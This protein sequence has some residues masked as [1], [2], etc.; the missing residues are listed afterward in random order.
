MLNEKRTNIAKIE[1]RNNVHII[2]VPNPHM[3]TPHFEVER[4]RD[5]STVVTQNENSY[6]L[7]ETPEQPPYE[8]RKASENVRA[9][10]AVTSIAP[11]APAPEHSAPAAK[12]EKKAQEKPSLFKRIITA[13]FGET[14]NQA[15]PKAASKP[16][17]STPTKSDRDSS[18]KPNNRT[19]RNKRNVRAPK[20]RSR[21]QQQQRKEPLNSSITTRTS[22]SWL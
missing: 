6:T 5:D 3:E 21:R 15:K 11:K 16:S 13:L 1:K 19:N 7:V 4:I 12:T 2:L 18:N 9:Q 10:A 22:G 14:Q 8:P 20:C 17:P